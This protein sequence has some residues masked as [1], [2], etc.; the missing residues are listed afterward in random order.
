M[1]NCQISRLCWLTYTLPILL[2]FVGSA[3][4]IV[5]VFFIT[6]FSIT[7]KADSILSIVCNSTHITVAICLSVRRFNYDML[8]YV[9]K[10]RDFLVAFCL[11]FTD[12]SM[13]IFGALF[14]ED[15]DDCVECSD[16]VYKMCRM[17]VSW[18]AFLVL[19]WLWA[20]FIIF[21]CQKRNASNRHDPS[22][23]INVNELQKID[24]EK[25]PKRTAEE[26]ET[27]LVCSICHDDYKV[28]EVLRLLKVCPHSFHAECVDK[29]ILQHSTCPI[30]RS[31]ISS[32]IKEDIKTTPT[33]LSEV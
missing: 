2:G 4:I 18:I 24:L 19:S 8:H 3:G 30:C 15:R 5:T 1:P 31:D 13:V 10:K 29:W 9:L 7:I 14:I 16:F 6:A 22:E 33:T 26:E 25:L 32:V 21:V 27:N 11:P 28:G 17:T 12:W 23:A 20:S